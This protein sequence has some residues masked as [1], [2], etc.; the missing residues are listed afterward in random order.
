MEFQPPH[1]GCYATTPHF[2]AKQFPLGGVSPLMRPSRLGF[3]F[4]ALA[5]FAS[6]SLAADSNGGFSATLSTEEQTAAGLTRLSAD[7]QTTLNT[8]VAREVSLARQG[9]VKAFAGTFSSRRKPAERTMAGLDRLTPTE[10]EQL[11]RLVATAIAAGPAPATLPRRLKASDVA[12]RADRLEIH[13]E[14]TLAYGWGSGGRDMRAGSLYTEIYDKETGVT[15]GL[16]YSQFSG[17]G[18]WGY[19]APY[20]YCDDYLV[21]GR[22]L[23]PSP[24]FAHGPISFR[25]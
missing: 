8:L 10:L 20:Y 22:I 9:N 1:V 15:L 23:L 21:P 16:G 4:V 3:L 25:R 12:A 2:T 13:G 24:R 18:W 19:G 7:E 5:V 6:A 14:V 17:D 11:D